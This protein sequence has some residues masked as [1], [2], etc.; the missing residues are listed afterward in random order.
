MKQ[1]ILLWKV[2]KIVPRHVFQ[3]LLSDIHCPLIFDNFIWVLIGLLF[4]FFDLFF[5]PTTVQLIYSLFC[6]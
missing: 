6:F 3:Y 1:Y 5:L 2:V 4:M